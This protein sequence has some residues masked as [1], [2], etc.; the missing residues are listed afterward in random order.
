MKEIE[1]KILEEIK[2]LKLK[3]GDVWTFQ[4]YNAFK[5]TLLPPEQRL[6]EQCIK[7]LCEKEYLKE[8]SYNSTFMYRLTQQGDERIYPDKAGKI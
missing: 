7:G 3:A 2:R 5:Y 6:F 1:R 8:E 4:L